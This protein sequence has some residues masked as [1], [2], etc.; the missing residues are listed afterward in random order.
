MF[1]VLGP[2]K[3]LPLIDAT[4][5]AAALVLRAPGGQVECSQSRRWKDLPIECVVPTQ[6]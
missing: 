3:G 6:P 5:G 1:G 4:P 2:A